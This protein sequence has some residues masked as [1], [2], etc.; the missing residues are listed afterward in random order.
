MLRYEHGGDIYADTRIRLDFSININP[1]G[2]PEA[3]RAAVV[4][5]LD[6]YQNY[7][8][9]YCRELR[10]ALAARENVDAAH[11]LCGNGASDLI[12]RLCASQ[13]PVKALICAPTFSEYERAVL[14][15]G[16]GVMYHTLCEDECFDLTDRILDDIDRDV[17]MVFISNPNNPTGRLVDE[18]LLDHVAR[19]CAEV[20][21]LLVVDEC[22]LPFTKG[23]SLVRLLNSMKS[24]VVLRAFTKIYAMPGLRLGYILSSNEDLVAQVRDCAQ[25]W[26]VSGVAQAAGLAALSC[27]GLEQE[28]RNLIVRERQ[29]L[30]GALSELGFSVVESQA[31]YIL[32]KSDTPL[33]EPLLPEGILLRSCENFVGLG[34]GYYRTGIKLHEQNIELIHAIA[35]VTDG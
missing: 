35:R 3:V 34:S 31:N 33:C 25:C 1:L 21:A 30:S 14:L 17:D 20:N 16:G 8:D 18:E 12:Y 10:S 13:K 11:I 23:S 5:H 15:Y 9:P 22:F 29:Y 24:I 7:P 27:D 26:S 28:T 19:R 6:D 2:M 4:S 32:F